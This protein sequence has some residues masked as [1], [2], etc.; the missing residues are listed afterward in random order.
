MKGSQETTFRALQLI[1][2][3]AIARMNDELLITN[4]Q[5]RDDLHIT[6]AHNK[7]LPN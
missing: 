3:A 6:E 5:E 7:L 4:H 1:Q 2:D